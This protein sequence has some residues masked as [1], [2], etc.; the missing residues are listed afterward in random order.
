[1][2]KRSARFSSQAVEAECA[3]EQL[4]SQFG[5]AL[6]KSE[7]DEWGL[8]LLY[9]NSTT[10]L[11]LEYSPAEQKGWRAVIGRLVAGS[12][13]KHPIY[14]TQDTDLQRFDLRD[15]AAERAQNPPEIQAKVLSG[16]PLTVT[17]LSEITSRSATDVLLGD[18]SVFPALRLRV[19]AR[20][21]AN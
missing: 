2:H 20:V 15:L 21:S 9:R 5:L 18:F 12:F 19:L 11:Q 1:M 6:V 8:T 16:A 4:R 14:I 13:P 7:E 10:G 3:I 17:E